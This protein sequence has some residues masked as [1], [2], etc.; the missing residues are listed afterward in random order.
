MPIQLAEITDY[1]SLV[2]NL[3]KL[4]EDN[5]VSKAQVDDILQRQTLSRF[6]MTG[7]HGTNEDLN[8]NMISV[9][10]LIKIAQER[11][12]YNIK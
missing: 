11:H 10:Q 5:K 9:D 7:K 2:I 6:F 4:A 1:V 8:E 3:I 12:T